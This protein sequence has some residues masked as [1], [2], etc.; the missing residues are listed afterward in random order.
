MVIKKSGKIALQKHDFK[1]YLL[2]SNNIIAAYIKRKY[3]LID[4]LKQEIFPGEK[5]ESIEDFNNNLLLA[6]QNGKWVIINKSGYYIVDHTFNSIGKINKSHYEYKFSNLVG[7]ADS[8]GQVIIEPSFKDIKYSG[9]NIIQ[10]I[11]LKDIFYYDQ[12]KGEWIYT[13]KNQMASGTIK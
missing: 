7:L 1:K 9:K 8:D 5:L 12:I 3:I 2:L 11:A 10:A 4:S 13:N 6:R